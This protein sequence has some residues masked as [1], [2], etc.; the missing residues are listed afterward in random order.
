[1]PW[2]WM[3]PQ[4]FKIQFNF[5]YLNFSDRV[6][7][8]YPAFT[9]FGVLHF[10]VFIYLFGFFSNDEILL[11]V[12]NKYCTIFPFWTLK[13]LTESILFSFWDSLNATMIGKDEIW[14]EFYLVTFILK[15]LIFVQ[16]T[17]HAVW[18]TFWV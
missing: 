16:H 5:K 10:Y 18:Q 9:G 2:L 6:S 17:L 8:Y 4:I 7:K 1:M 11:S 15:F 12:P 14:P 13:L 3:H